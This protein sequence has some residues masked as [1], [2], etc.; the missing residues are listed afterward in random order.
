[1]FVLELFWLQCH[2]SR[3]KYSVFLGRK[4]PLYPQW[5]SVM[6][7]GWA[8][9]FK[10][11][12]LNIST[13]KWGSKCKRSLVTGVAHWNLCLPG[14]SFTVK[15]FRFKKRKNNASGVYFDAASLCLAWASCSFHGISLAEATLMNLSCAFGKS[16][17]AVS[18][19]WIRLACYGWE[20]CMCVSVLWCIK[21]PFLRVLRCVVCSW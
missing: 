7:M 8:G 2:S 16:P 9:L 11:I 10:F 1:M 20:V 6:K 15:E 14:N 4:M 12:R 18:R 13:F 17:A 19:E 3:S 5:T 21:Q